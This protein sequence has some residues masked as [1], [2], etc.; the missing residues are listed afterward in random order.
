[1]YIKKASDFLNSKNT[2]AVE[3]FGFRKNISSDRAL[4]S[5]TDELLHA[6]NTEMHIG[7]ISRDPDE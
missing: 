6:V 3:H 4:C 5:F 7:V 2:L 1:M